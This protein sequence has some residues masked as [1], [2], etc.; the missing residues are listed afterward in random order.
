MRQNCQGMGKRFVIALSLFLSAIF[1]CHADESRP[2]ILFF[3]ADDQRH[4]TLGCAGHK[5]VETPTIDRLA[6][7]GVRFENMFVTRSTCWASRTTILTGLTSRSS[8]EPDRSDR[9]KPEALTE[10]FPDLLRDAGYRTGLFGKWHAKMPKGFRPEDHFDEYEKIFRNPYFKTM[11][12]GT[13]RHTTELIGDR[14]IEFL[15]TQRGKKRPFCLNLWFNAGHAEDRDLVPGIGHYPW[16]RAMDGKYEDVT[17]P[18]PRLSAP[19]IYESHPEFF[20]KS[21]HRERF[22]WRW[23]T[24]EKYQANMRAYFRMLTGI[25]HVIN[26]VLQT[27]KEEGLAENTIVV[28]AADNGYY[29]GDRGFAGKWSHHEQSLRVPLVIYDP[30]LPE[31]LR[32]LTVDT[33][34]LNLD[35]PSTFLDWAGV[36]VP[37]SYQGTSLKPVIEG[38]PK[39]EGWR[40]DFFCEH[41]NP[42]YSMSWEGVRGQ[43]FKYARY[44]DQEPAF[45]YLHDLQNDPSELINLSGNAEYR[46]I[47]K[48]MRQRT[49]TLAEDYVKALTATVSPSKNP[50]NSDANPRTNQ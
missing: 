27:L 45:E 48:Q 49:D 37:A 44:V 38:E 12:D 3:F 25:D 11:P 26:R 30:R 41:F 14:G 35:L 1:S 24:P 43:R 9:V 42:R 40:K 46:A 15:K 50:G 7:S 18:A 33:M 32:G 17:I 2:N 6:N 28:Y 31:E 23:D 21:N 34:A 22:H 29:M 5:I 16:P 20:K 36:P 8:V 19:E 4:D 10:M 13:R 39:P 47:L